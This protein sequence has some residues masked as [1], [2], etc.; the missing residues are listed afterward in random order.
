MRLFFMLD[1]LI[2]GLATWRISSLIA[3]ENGPWDVLARF[4]DLAGVRYDQMSQRY[5]LNVF[6]SLVMC[7]WCLSPWV[8]LGVYVSYRVWPTPTL[9]VATVLALSA[10]AVVVE[11]LV[12]RGDS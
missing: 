4:R 2:L 12:N 8:G 7:V 9:T 11:E 6:G 1:L 3:N 10:F 5:G